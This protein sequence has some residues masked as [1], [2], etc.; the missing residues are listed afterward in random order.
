[1][2][3]VLDVVDGVL[4]LVLGVRQ[5]LLD[6]P[7]GPV[8]L[9]LTLEIGVVGEVADGFLGPALQVVALGCWCRSR[10]L[11]RR[12]GGVSGCFGGPVSVR[13]RPG[14][15]PRERF[16]ETRA[17]WFEPALRVGTAILT[18]GPGLPA[19]RTLLAGGISAQAPH[20]QLEIPPALLSP[21]CPG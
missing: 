19:P 20:D 6:L 11:L 12:S 13:R 8:G 1:M 14:A 17:K 18:H 3:L 21:K 16:R 2:E 7:G 4:E 5:L 9:A 10:W 15:Y